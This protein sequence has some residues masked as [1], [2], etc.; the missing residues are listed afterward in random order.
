MELKPCF[1]LLAGTEVILPDPFTHTHWKLVL[2]VSAS[3]RVNV[4]EMENRQLQERNLKLSNQASSSE[5]A[6]RMVQSL[7]G[8]EVKRSAHRRPSLFLLVFLG[9][10]P[11]ANACLSLL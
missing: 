3:P 10:S 2:T 4:L 1:Q 6:L 5:R 8:S 9:D 7:Y 11:P